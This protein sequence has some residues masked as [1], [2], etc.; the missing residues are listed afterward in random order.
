MK[1]RRRMFSSG[2]KSSKR[3]RS[4]QEF[5]P[6]EMGIERSFAQQQSNVGH[7]AFGSFSTAARPAAGLAM[8][9]VSPK[10]EAKSEYWHR[11]WSDRSERCAQ[12]L[13]AEGDRGANRIP[14]APHQRY[15]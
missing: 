4:N 3:R 5:A 2:E 10:A 6:G 9:A 12:R 14:L 1:S 11:A 13:R 8:S 7:V 15:P